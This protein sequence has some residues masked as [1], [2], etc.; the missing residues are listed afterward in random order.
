MEHISGCT[1][2]VGFLRG[3]SDKRLM[4]EP[5]AGGPVLADLHARLLLIPPYEVGAVITNSV[6]IMHPEESRDAGNLLKITE[7][8]GRDGPCIQTYWPPKPGA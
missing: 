4:A 7:L 5:G 8:R 6:Q 1:T 3:D 2:G